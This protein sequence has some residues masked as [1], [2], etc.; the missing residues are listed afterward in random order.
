MQNFSSRKNKTTEESQFTKEKATDTNISMIQMLES[1]DRYFKVALINAPM[2]KI[3][4]SWNKWK[5]KKS[6]Q[7]NRKHE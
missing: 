3:K 6:Q 1:S 7:R 4:H 2:S 5:N